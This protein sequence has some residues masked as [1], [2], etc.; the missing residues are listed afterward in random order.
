MSQETKQ[1]SKQFI[2][3]LKIILICLLILAVLGIGMRLIQYWRLRYNTEQAA[4]LSVATVLAAKSAAFVEIILPGNVQAWHE[5]TIYARTNGYVLKWLVDIGAYVKTG[6]LL[7]QIATPEV[8]A[9]LRQAEADL[10]TAEANN[11]LAQ[12]T[13]KRWIILWKTDSVSKQETDEKISDAK[14]KA[15]IEVA[16]RANRDRL[17]DLVSFERVV[18]PFD[19]VIT[20]RLTDIGRLINAGSGTVPLFRMAQTNPL[21]VYVRV[22]EYYSS[23]VKPGITTVLQFPQHPGKSYPA[24]LLDTAKAIDVVTRT[25]LVQ[26]QVANPNNDLFAGSYTEVHLKLPA[27]NSV[28]L[29][30]N[31]LIFRAE[32]MQVATIDGDHQVVIKSIMIGRDYGDVVEVVNGVKPNEAV[33]LNPP[34]SLLNGQEVR[35]ISTKP[36]SKE[37]IKKA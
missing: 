18:A 7:A 8:N 35:I 32:G 23:N 31:T 14:A 12:T 11:N 4:V 29:P 28:L 20:S 24:V 1:F 9:Q 2:R 16:T 5:S 30:V 13:A 10:K 17:K 22:P 33:I 26:F 25:L 19:G 15:A 21:R 27:Q 34:D 36:M 37:E 6:D 3:R